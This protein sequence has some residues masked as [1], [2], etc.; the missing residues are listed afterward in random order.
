MYDWKL[1]IAKKCGADVC[2]NPSKSNVQ[3]EIAKLSSGYGCD[4]YFEVTGNPASVQ[5]GLNLLRSQGKF[6]CMSIFKSDV[7]ADWSLIGD[8]KELQIIGGHL[9]PHCWPK[10]IDMVHKNQLPM[11]D[12]V[13]H[14]FPLSQFNE[15]IQL[16]VNSADS[17]KVMLFP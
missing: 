4:A 3:F 8:V 12:I 7:S 9:G 6:I 5:Q 1:D 10:A 15:G 16:V 2:L 13:T 14:K 17:I 11:D